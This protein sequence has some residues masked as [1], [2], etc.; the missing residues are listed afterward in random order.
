MHRA[1]SCVVSPSPPPPPPVP[2]PE[3]PPDTVER[4][5]WRCLTCDDQSQSYDDLVTHT[6]IAHPDADLPRF[7][8]VVTYVPKAAKAPEPAAP[9]SPPPLPTG[10]ASQEER[11]AAILDAA[12]VRGA[13]KRRAP[14]ATKVPVGA[15]RRSVPAMVS[16]SYSNMSRRYRA[17]QQPAVAAAAAADE[18][19]KLYCYCQSPYDEVSEMIGCDNDDCQH[20]WFHFECVG[21]VIAPKGKW[22]C[23]DCADR[24]KA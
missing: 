1:L 9:P 10:D 19:D 11:D 2:K 21:I 24:N 18:M 3:P 4:R 17:P 14:S 20:E 15:K 16:P 12:R 23:P 6:Y 13:E 7:Q 8:V 22:F 5:R